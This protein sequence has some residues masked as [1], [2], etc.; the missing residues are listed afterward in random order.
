MNQILPRLKKCDRNDL[1]SLPK[2]DHYSLLLVEDDISD[3]K[4]VEEA[5]SD[6]TVAEVNLCRVDNAVA[7]VDQLMERQFDIILL[8]SSLP[9]SPRLECFHQIRELAADAPIVVLAERRDEPVMDDVVAAGAEQCLFK[10]DLNRRTIARAVYQS[11]DHPRRPIR[12]SP[13]PDSE[14]GI[15]SKSSISPTASAPKNARPRAQDQADRLWLQMSEDVP[16]ALRTPLTG[17]REYCS[18]V[19][20][21]LT[22]SVNPEQFKCLDRAVDLVDDV[23]MLLNCALE[24][25]R[26]EAG[27]FS[28]WRESSS[29][30]RIIDSLLPSIRRKAAMRNLAVHVDVPA[31]LPEVYCDSEL[32]SRAISTLAFGAMQNAVDGNLFELMTFANPSESE[33]VIKVRLASHEASA[34]AANNLETSAD[35]VN[36]LWSRWLTKIV[37]LNLGELRIDRSAAGLPNYRFAVPLADPETVVG[38]YIQIRRRKLDTSRWIS[39]VTVEFKQ[40]LSAQQAN[41]IEALLH[42]IMRVDDL[43]FRLDGKRWLLV[44]EVEQGE[45][46]SPLDEIRDA[47]AVANRNRTEPL[48]AVNTTLKAFY[49]I[50]PLKSDFAVQQAAENEAAEQETSEESLSAVSPPVTRRILL[51]DDEPTLIQALSLR[52]NLLGYEVLTAADGCEGLKLAAEHLPGL[53]VLDIRMPKM[54][55]LTMLDQLRNQETTAGIP[56]VMVSA[57]HIDRRQ[58]LQRGARYF[59]EKPYDS[60]VLVA[61]ITAALGTHASC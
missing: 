57:S 12:S 15:A 36:H 17:I 39:L 52:L 46:D 34:A 1:D 31:D 2:P 45:E 47:W 18:L 7:A 10:D 13:L 14:A 30:G 23:N 9:D 38:R 59:L 44:V 3:A 11:L 32:V 61:T 50:L 6:S 42:K 54:D 58:A 28:A 29:L 37:Q 16:L 8:D 43:L 35:P 27:T 49:N 4:K 19:R 22:G 51:V 60:Q 33:V 5:L 24:I 25:D 55:G 26:L 20:D 53:I 21:G 41:V 56:V 40:D 48:P